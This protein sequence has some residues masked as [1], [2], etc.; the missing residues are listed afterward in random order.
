M[1]QKDDMVRYGAHGVCKVEDITEKNFNGEAIRYYVLRP[2]YNDTST[3]YVPIHN[4]AL[5]QNMRKVLSKEELQSLIQ[6][7]PHEESLWIENEEVRKAQYQEILASGNRAGLIGMLKA[8]YLHQRE[9]QVRPS[10]PHLH[11]CHQAHQPLI[12]GMTKQPLADWRSRQQENRCQQRRETQHHRRRGAHNLTQMRGVVVVLSNQL[13]HSVKDTRPG[14]NTEY[15]HQLA[16]VSRLAD[17]R[18]AKRDGQQFNHQ[19]P[20]ANFYQRGRGGPH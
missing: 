12:M 6:T 5:T 13:G 4:H 9:Q 19:Q 3:I 18:G 15:S 1:F 8:L 2:I 16:E 20:N 17:A 7:M 11:Q 14:Q 10:D